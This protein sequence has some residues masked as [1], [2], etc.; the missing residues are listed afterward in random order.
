MDK[1]MQKKTATC[2]FDK[3]MHRLGSLVRMNRGGALGDASQNEVDDDRELKEGV[4]E[5]EP[6]DGR[7]NLAMDEKEVFGFMA[8]GLSRPSFGGGVDVARSKWPILD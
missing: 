2:L 7:E 6:L 4:A 3:V 1:A 5:D 8:G